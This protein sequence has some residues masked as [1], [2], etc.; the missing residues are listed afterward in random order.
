[1]KRLTLNLG[2]RFD[3]FN[4]ISPSSVGPAQLV[5][6]RDFTFPETPW[7]NWK[8]ITPRLGATYDLFGNG[9]TALKASR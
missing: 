3:Y 9:K 1:M 5:P 2:V 4:A 8:D 6:N 7:T